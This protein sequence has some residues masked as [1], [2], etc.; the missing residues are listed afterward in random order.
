MK[1]VK[2]KNYIIIKKNF[3][4]YRLFFKFKIINIELISN[5]HNNYF[6]KFFKIKNLRRLLYKTL[7]IHP[8]L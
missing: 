6:I 2:L 5:N 1:I 7:L 4:Y 8:L 3:Y